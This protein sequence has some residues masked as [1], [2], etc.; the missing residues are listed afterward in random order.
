MPN[1][2]SKL[3][4]NMHFACNSDTFSHCVSQP[5]RLLAHAY[6]L[7]PIW[8]AI[9]LIQPLFAVCKAS[10]Y[11]AFALRRVRAIEEGNVLITDVPKPISILVPHSSPSRFT[12]IFRNMPAP[13]QLIGENMTY[14]C[15]LLE[16]SNNPSAILCTGASP[17]LS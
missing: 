5:F 12:P 16:S 7:E 9:F 11:A 4:G 14:Q 1:R 13:G 6:E 8:P 10:S 2:P 17:H 15:I 3:Q